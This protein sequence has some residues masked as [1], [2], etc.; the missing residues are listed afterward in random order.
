ME[1]VQT[2]TAA[3]GEEI[4]LRPAVPDD[5]C[6]II[7][8]LRSAS[9]ER[10][11]VLMEQYGNDREAECEYIRS[12]D[13]SHNLLLVAVGKGGVVGSLAALQ[14]DAG[15]RPHTAHVLNV[16]LH[17]KDDH[18]GIGIGTRMLHYA[19]QWAR[20]HGYLKLAASIFT[21]NKRS[22]HVFSKAGF[23]EECLKRKHIRLGREYIDEVCVGMVLE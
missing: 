5:A 21:T 2:F 20:E 17:L 22:L 7:D 23:V 19:I 18:R 3:N 15:T 12:L 16:G 6:E 8:T 13:W 10:S 9:S 14:A 11:Y 4:T 1:E